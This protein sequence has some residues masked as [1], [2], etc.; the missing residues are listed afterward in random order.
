MKSFRSSPQAFPDPLSTATGEG[1]RVDPASPGL[2]G[3]A[4]AAHPS[5][6]SAPHLAHRTRFCAALALVSDILRLLATGLCGNGCNE[7]LGM[8]DDEQEEVDQHHERQ[9][10][11]HKGEYEAE[12]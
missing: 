11:A 2:D 1:A 12:E 4:T 8:D 3:T 6:T 10:E 5:S 9:E 7:Y